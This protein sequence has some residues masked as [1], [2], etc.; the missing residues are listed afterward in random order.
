MA[1][2]FRGSND[3]RAPS[4]TAAIPAPPNP[5]GPTSSPQPA[6]AADNKAAADA[7]NPFMDPSPV[8]VEEQKAEPEVDVMDLINKAKAQQA[9]RPQILASPNFVLIKKGV[10]KRASVQSKGALSRFAGHSGPVT[11]PSETTAEVEKK[12]SVEGQLGTSAMA[13]GG[14]T[15]PDL[16]GV[17][18]DPQQQQQQNSAPI[19]LASKGEN[20]L[21]V[22]KY[23]STSG[24]AKPDI[25]SKEGG[26]MYNSPR[27][28]GAC[29][30]SKYVNSKIISCEC[31]IL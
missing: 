15:E 20:P 3:N 11:M 17:T 9:K 24:M 7:A 25:H 31:V 26:P 30:D 4:G 21:S 23:E 8:K 12:N 28:G 1:Y 2:S 10:N 19:T 6:T 22:L 18:K 27:N 5:P 13:V 29:C 16:S 14:V